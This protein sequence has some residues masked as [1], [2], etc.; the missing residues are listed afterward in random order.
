MKT[1]DKI[2]LYCKGAGIFGTLCGHANVY[3]CRVADL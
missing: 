3:C 2:M 1:E